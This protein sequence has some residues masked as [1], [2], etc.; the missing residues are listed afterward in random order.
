MK[1]APENFF[2]NNDFFD[3]LPLFVSINMIFPVE[4]IIIKK[5]TFILVTML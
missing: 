4:K 1:N 5:L 3:I 2:F